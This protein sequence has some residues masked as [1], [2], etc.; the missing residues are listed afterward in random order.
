MPNPP[1]P[2]NPATNARIATDLNDFKSHIEGS[3][4]KQNAASIDTEPGIGGAVDLQTS[5]NNLN[6][7]IGASIEN[8]VGYISVPRDGYNSYTFPSPGFYFNNSIPSLDSFLNPIFNDILT[9]VAL[10]SAYARI[11]NGGVVL[12]PAGTYYVVNPITVPP[13]ITLL[14]EGYGTKI[15][16][17]IRLNLASSPPIV[18]SGIT[19][20]PVFII[21]ADNN[22]SNND[23]AVDPT[24]TF[25]FGRATQFLNLTI[26]DNFVEPTL[27]GD[28][29]YVLPQNDGSHSTPT[30]G[31]I[32]QNQGSNF[33]L[34]NVNLVGRVRF[35]SGT[36]VSS[37]T[38]FAVSL[39]TTL[40]ITTG[41]Y[42]KISNC[43]I[44]GFSQ[45]VNFKSKGGCFDYLEISNSKIRAHGYLNGDGSG[46]GNHAEN[47]CIV[48]MNDNNAKIV[49]NDLF[50]NH[51][52]CFTILSILGTL[53]SPPNLD[54]ISKINISSNTFVIDRGDTVP[55][56]PVPFYI[57]SAI[58][59]IEN[60]AAV[61]AFGNTYDEATGFEVIV[62]KGSAGTAQ[63]FVTPTNTAI[64][65]YITIGA[66]TAAS[67][68]IRLASTFAM[69]NTASSVDY[70]LLST[71]GNQLYVGVDPDD[72]S[73]AMIGVNIYPASTNAWGIDDATYL[74]AD[75]GNPGVLS[76]YGN[77][78]LAL[79]TGIAI[80]A[81]TGRIRLANTDGIFARDNANLN[82]QPLI[83][84]DASDDIIIG[85]TV[86]TLNTVIHAASV[87][88]LEPGS[89]F[90][91]IENTGVISVSQSS[92][93]LTGTS[94]GQFKFD[95]SSRPVCADNVNNQMQMSAICYSLENDLVQATSGA[96]VP[97]NL[98]F[99]VNATDIWHIYVEGV[100]KCSTSETIYPTLTVPVGATLGSA[101]FVGG[102]SPSGVGND[103]TS[104]VAWSAGSTIGLDGTANGFVGFIYNARVK[105]D[106]T[107]SGN[108]TFNIQPNGL[109]A[110]TITVKAGTT[111]I[112]TPVFEV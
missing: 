18:N 86:V 95:A 20:Q 72:I 101:N 6:S 21:A 83:Q 105:M 109:S 104:T 74:F 35:S 44:D 32:K 62:G 19:P 66:P 39:D 107:H 56:V 70:T 11:Q 22:R 55:I 3:G 84:T 13:G 45:P 73:H 112:A 10:P 30:V 31:L 63:L 37:A 57:D 98:S 79:G 110:V 103:V 89:A 8:G 93:T 49:S 46:S 25:M 5:L 80:P 17:A 65:N 16:N 9:N 81:T 47:N 50:G 27:L 51:H 58:T 99:A 4:F 82:D 106:G 76:V 61:V 41:T 42:L 53:T 91:E 75:I 48:G 68:D 78:D 71:N 33:V 108:I 23:G 64:P 52:N 59:T 85:D 24:N 111:L 54:G 38:Q 102:T 77:T 43:I 97:T 12:I 28:L 15:V 7:F 94:F 87:V 88:A 90:L 60:F 14:G 34:E 92:A 100:I 2:F 26:C 67:G 36:V 1:A 29:N 40:P 69:R 96:V